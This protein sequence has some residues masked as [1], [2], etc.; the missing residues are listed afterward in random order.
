MKKGHLFVVSGPSGAGKTSLIGRFL[1]EDTA[2]GFSVSFTT[3]KKRENETDGKDYHFVA[4][5]T[6]RRMIEEEKFLEW[7]QVHGYYYGTPL[8][9]V[10][11]I[12]AGGT[13]VILD[14]DVK[15]ALA[16]KNRCPGA[17]LIFIEPPAKEELVKRLRLR[18]EK[19][20]D[21]R[22]EIVQEEMEKKYF[23]E[24]SII[25]NEIDNA[26]SVFKNVI[27]TVREQKDGKNN[28]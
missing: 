17:C 3:R 7:E 1:K 28:C 11:D 27:Q 12:L 9:G 18:G 14:I 25:N 19:E 10:L 2:S 4:P 21:R 13:D 5:D 16:V 23:F 6:F 20:I 8:Q 22:M 15:G 24:Y 26:Y